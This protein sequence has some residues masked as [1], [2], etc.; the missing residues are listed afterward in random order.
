MTD[1]V[2][3][4][5][6]PVQL[7]NALTSGMQLVLLAAGLTIILGMQ[8]IFNFAHGAFYMVG[9]YLTYVAFA[10]LGTGISLTEFAI[11]VV[12]AFVV[13]GLIGMAIEAVLLRPLASRE[14]AP[15]HQLI[16][17]FGLSIVFIEVVKLIW[18]PD[19]R[20]ASTPPALSGSVQL[21][22][23]TYPTYWL[24]TIVF[25]GLLMLGLAALFKYTKTGTVIRAITY[26]SEMAAVLG[27]D[28]RRLTLIVFGLGSG[29]AG[30][31][32]VIGPPVVG[33]GVDP[34]MGTRIIVQIIVVIIFGGL[35]SIRG[36]VVAGL[37]I[38]AVLTYGTILAGSFMAQVLIAVI[39]VVMLLIRPEGLYGKRGVLE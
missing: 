26:D 3:L 30:V 17:T 9:A 23:V 21:G 39:L 12:L 5:L 37:I 4:L 28:V 38:G 25:S 35:G 14:E 11:G 7:L 16:L 33:A 24:F 22:Q 15:L 27:H 6:D 18:G 31:A 2:S 19:F 1:I 36:T 32:G 10:S 34:E 20:S 8:G 13:L 29:I